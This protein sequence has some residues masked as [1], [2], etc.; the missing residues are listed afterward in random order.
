LL[1]PQRYLTRI[2]EVLA[3]LGPRD[4]VAASVMDVLAKSDQVLVGG[5]SS[6]NVVSVSRKRPVTCSFRVTNVPVLG[7]IDLKI[8]FAAGF[9]MAG[10]RKGEKDVLANIDS[11]GIET[12][13]GKV[14]SLQVKEDSM[15]LAVGVVK[16]PIEYVPKKPS[17]GP[18]VESGVCEEKASL[19]LHNSF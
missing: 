4:P 7:S 1:F 17:T 5:A 6:S 9:G 3:T 19:A 13:F 2:N 11:Y 15:V 10:L 14:K 18:R 8:H 12:N 16:I